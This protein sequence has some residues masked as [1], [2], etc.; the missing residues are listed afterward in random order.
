MKLSEYITERLD[1]GEDN[2]TTVEGLKNNIRCGLLQAVTMLPRDDWN[3]EIRDRRKEADGQTLVWLAD[4][5][6]PSYSIQE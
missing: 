2:E 3:T 4:Q 5:A 6:D 1:G